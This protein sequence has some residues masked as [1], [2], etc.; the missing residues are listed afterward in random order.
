M[1]VLQH[2]LFAA[3]LA[4]GSYGCNNDDDI[5]EPS[6]HPVVVYKDKIARTRL[7]QHHYF[8][9]R[10]GILGDTSFFL[11]DTTF[12]IGVSGDTAFLFGLF[13]LKHDS[14]ITSAQTGDSTLYF[15][16]KTVAHAFVSLKYA[17]RGDSARVRYR[18][19]GLGGYYVRSF[20]TK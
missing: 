5:I 19:G 10:G 15:S 9:T 17:T 3:C 14:T 8:I 18:D 11:P 1:R 20:A 12:S 4:F 7:W 6:R 16:I 2:F 13:P